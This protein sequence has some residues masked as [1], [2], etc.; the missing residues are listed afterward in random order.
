MKLRSRRLSRMGHELNLHPVSYLVPFN[1]A[2]LIE[3]GTFYCRK[4]IEAVE[5]GQSLLEG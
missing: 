2:M 5:A 4:A 3:A 1:A